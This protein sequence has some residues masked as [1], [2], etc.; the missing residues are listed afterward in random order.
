ML[1]STPSSSA[2]TNRP[3]PALAPVSA[4]AASTEPNLILRQRV[5]T[6]AVGITTTTTA[7]H[8]TGTAGYIDPPTAAPELEAGPPPIYDPIHY[9]RGPSPSLH[10][11]SPGSSSPLPGG[12]GNVSA[13]LQDHRTRK[14][15]IGPGTR[16]VANLTP[17]QLAKKRANGKSIF[18]YTLAYISCYI[19]RRRYSCR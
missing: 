2:S 17:E 7:S 14:R 16:G 1:P 12:R 8:P 18:S 10:N 15:R 9:Q 3:A 13:I 19:T 5:Y 6:G 4:A 11:Q